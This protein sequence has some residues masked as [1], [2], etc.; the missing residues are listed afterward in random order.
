MF[1][2]LCV[3][4]AI[5]CAPIIHAHETPS[6]E[7]LWSLIQEQK[8]EIEELKTQLNEN[9]ASIQETRVVALSVAD[10]VESNPSNTSV[11]SSWAEK[12]S[13]GGY[14]EH[15]YNVVDQGRDQIDAHRFV[16][17]AGHEY[18]D[19]VRFFSE[20]EIEHSLAGDGKPGEVE[21]EQAFVEYQYAQNH[22]IKIGQY[23]IP[24]GILNEIHEP[25]T[26]YGVERNK[27]ESEIIPSTWWESGVMLSGRINQTLTYDFAV[28]SG[29]NLSDDSAAIDTLRIR[30]GR[31]KSAEANANNLAYTGRIKATPLPGLELSA[32]L[33][34]QT[35][36]LQSMVSGDTAEA[37]LY[38]AHAIYQGEKLGLRAMYAGWDIDNLQFE[39]VNSD[40][41][42][43]WYIEPSWMLNKNW[44]VF[45][46]YSEVDPS[47]GDRPTQKTEQIDVGFNYWLTPQVVLKA[48]YQDSREDGSDAFNLGVGWSF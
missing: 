6:L 43:G 4:I 13:I 12:T 22:N 31:Q 35:D 7:E 9:N 15:H 27:V 1:K 45:A 2:R 14:G 26:F 16:L 38:E 28:H 17:Y 46:R 37:L 20:L 47:R 19:R 36:M 11:S 41:P 42:T 24:V 40:D 33:Q 8:A 32:T 48:D 23:L 10:A 34:Y 25:D 21:L 39:T 3:A 18:S 29:L 44:G 30:S 5:S